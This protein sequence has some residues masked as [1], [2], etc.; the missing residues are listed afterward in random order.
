MWRRA[1][2]GCTL[3]V[4]FCKLRSVFPRRVPKPATKK[5]RHVID[6]CHSKVASLGLPETCVTNDVRVHCYLTGAMRADIWT[7]DVSIDYTQCIMSSTYSVSY[8]LHTVYHIIYIQCIMSSTYS[9]S[10]HLYT[11][12]H[13]IYIQCIMSSIYTVSCHLYTVYHF[14]YIQCIMSTIY[15]V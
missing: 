11:V 13:F 8:H 14:I 9:I 5:W 4:C 12:Y 3:T 1:D 15:G 2:E 7:E 10:C 6:D